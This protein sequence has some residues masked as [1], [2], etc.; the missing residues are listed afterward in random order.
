MHAFLSTVEPCG[1]TLTR[2]ETRPGGLIRG[3]TF[4]ALLSPRRSPVSVHSPLNSCSIGLLEGD[5]GAPASRPPAAGALPEFRARFQVED[6]GVALDWEAAPW[7]TTFFQAAWYEDRQPPLSV[8]FEGNRGFAV[9]LTNQTGGL[10]RQIVLV[11]KG[12]AFP[13]ADEVGEGLHVLPLLEETRER[14]D[15]WEQR[16]WQEYQDPAIPGAWRRSLS[17]DLPLDL[18]FD[19]YSYYGGRHEK[20]PAVLLAWSDLPAAPVEAAALRQQPETSTLYV[21]EVEDR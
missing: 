3:Q 2:V 15:K 7:S 11:R 14:C 9:Q 10:L 12:F 4:G 5:K 19:L 18:R 13:L 8:R 21:V 20:V 1:R 16:F 6:R 17:F